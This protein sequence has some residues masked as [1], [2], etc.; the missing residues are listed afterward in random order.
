MFRSNPGAAMQ[1][2]ISVEPMPA[3]NHSSRGINNNRLKRQQL[4][5]MQVKSLLGRTTSKSPPQP[6]Y[7]YVVSCWYSPWPQPT[8][9]IAPE[10]APP[11]PPQPTPQAVHSSPAATPHAPPWPRA[12]ATPTP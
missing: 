1:S 10:P 3:I 5:M 6:T 7:L 2:Y 4:V 12:P 11:P 9:D 8:Y